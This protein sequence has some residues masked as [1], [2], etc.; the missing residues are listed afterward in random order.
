MKKK[1][2]VQSGLKLCDLTIVAA[3]VEMKK[4]L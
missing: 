3:G 4:V 2:I 1:G